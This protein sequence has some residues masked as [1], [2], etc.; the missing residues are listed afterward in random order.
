MVGNPQ[1][2]YGLNWERDLVNRFKKYDPKARRNPNSGAFGT[3]AGIANLQGDVVF[4]VDGL[5]FLIEA[6]A[7]Y[8]GSL[9]MSV[10]REWMDKT[11]KEAENQRPKRIPLLALKFRNSKTDSGKLIALTITDF[12]KVM[13]RLLEVIEDL[14]EA[15]DFIFSLKDSGVDITEYT[16]G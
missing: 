10:K 3:Q 2:T 13:D 7:G 6:K 15:Q 4:T 1:R 5:P 11:I 9:S 16:K 8:G 14:A 12:E